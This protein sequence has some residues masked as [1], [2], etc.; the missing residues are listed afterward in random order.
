M[1]LSSLKSQLAGRGYKIT[2]PRRVI[3]EALMEKTGWVTAKDLYEEISGQ[4]D[5]IDFSTVCR[6]LDVLT[7]L[8]ILCRVDLENNGIFAYCMREKRE[9]HHHLICRSCGKTSLIETCPL[10]NLSSEQ[11]EGFSELEC[12]FEVY[13][14]CRDCRDRDT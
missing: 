11:T 6:N 8:E 14:I 1:D 3:L 2:R 10:A 4:V 7:G 13:G 5:H 12:R 9:H